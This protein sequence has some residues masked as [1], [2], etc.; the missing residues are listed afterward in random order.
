MNFFFHYF[1]SLQ[2]SFPIFWKGK[3]REREERVKKRDAFY[4]TIHGYPANVLGIGMI[5]WRYFF[6]FLIFLALLLFPPYNYFI[7]SIGMGLHSFFFFFALIL[8][9]P[10]FYFILFFVP[11]SFYSFFFFSLHFFI[12][13]YFFLFPF[14]SCSLNYYIPDFPFSDLFL[15]ASFPVSFHGCLRSTI[16]PSCLPSPPHS[17]PSSNSPIHF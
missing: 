15:S 12:L 2:D 10:I 8:F 4:N 5:F 9:F 16:V 3:V 7:I 6:H 17:F 14:F 13:F 1:L 11:F